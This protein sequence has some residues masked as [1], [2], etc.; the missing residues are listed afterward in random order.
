MSD[1]PTIERDG[2]DLV[3]HIPMT[4]KRRGG[5]REIIV[6]EGLPGTRPR[7]TVQ[8]PLVVA[9]ARAHRWQEW[10]EDG[11]YPS[12]AALAEAVGVDRT[13]VARLLNRTLLA[14]GL[15]EAALDGREPSGLSLEAIMQ[16]LPAA[17]TAQ[18]SAFSSVT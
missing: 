5:R 4:F 13:Y 2:D 3:I 7:S 15:V 8:A 11:T 14:P 10:I 17:W 6:P 18:A 9:L 12:I 16:A 1:G